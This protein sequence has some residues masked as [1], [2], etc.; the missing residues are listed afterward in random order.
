MNLIDPDG[1]EAG[2]YYRE[3]S[4]YIG[5]DGSIDGKKYVIKNSDVEAAQNILS[6]GSYYML[7]NFSIPLPNGSSISAIADGYQ[8]F[9]DNYDEM[10]DEFQT[11]IWEGY[12]KTEIRIKCKPAIY[13]GSSNSVGGKI[14]HGDIADY[15]NMYKT[16]G[17]GALFTV[18]S[19]GMASCW[20][21]VPTP[22]DFIFVSSGY[23]SS[24]IHMQ[25]SE[26]TN[27]VN[28]FNSKDHYASF[29]LDKFFSF[30]R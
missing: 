22:G 4:S 16:T 15:S 6:T 3:D 14:D 18:H 30:G 8:E 28:F 26:R 27:K 29:P 2:D 21:Q 9:I 25:I 24:T 10:N 12:N 1:M 19:H 20:V 7:S 17:Y 5:T 23:S 11:A 13:D